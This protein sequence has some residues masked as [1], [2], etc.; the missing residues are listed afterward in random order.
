MKAQRQLS[1]PG[2]EMARR[3]GASTAR[4]R[5]A[6]CCSARTSNRWMP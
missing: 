1:D 3:M 5:P 6:N 4:S 2:R